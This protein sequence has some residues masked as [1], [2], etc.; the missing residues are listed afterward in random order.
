MRFDRAIAGAL[1]VA[2]ASAV[3]LVSVP[4]ARATPL[5]YEFSGASAIV[6]GE[7]ETITGSFTFDT[8]DDALTDP[9]ITLTGT[10]TGTQIFDPGTIIFGADVGNNG[11]D[12]GNGVWY[13]EPVFSDPLDIASDPMSDFYVGDVST[14]LDYSGFEGTFGSVIEVPSGAVPEPTSLALLSAALGG[15]GLLRRRR[16]AA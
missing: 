2:A 5:N 14:G 10:L 4:V 15:L 11:F 6:V 1:V 12:V 9:S 7:T 3:C 13:L 8:A 16:K